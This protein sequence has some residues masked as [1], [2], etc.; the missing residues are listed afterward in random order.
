[1]YI[2]LQ[3]SAP[4]LHGI[5]HDTSFWNYCKNPSLV[6][7]IFL[8]FPIQLC[9]LDGIFVT[10]TFHSIIRISYKRETYTDDHQLK[11]WFSDYI[12][13]TVGDFIGRAKSACIINICSEKEIL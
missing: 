11:D 4:N 1:M 13:L 12:Q 7:I 2:V 6:W 5:I 8:H 10:L 3:R 9:K